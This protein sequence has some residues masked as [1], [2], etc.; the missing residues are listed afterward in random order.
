MDKYFINYDGDYIFSTG[1]GVGDKEITQEEY[2]NILSIINNRPK[3]ETGFAYKLRKD[4]T[5][6][7]VEVPVV[8]S[9]NDELSAEE[10]LD[11]ILGGTE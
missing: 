2:E 11:I 10:A 8:P 3:T 9:D 4:L 7:K 5:W 6:E 1:K